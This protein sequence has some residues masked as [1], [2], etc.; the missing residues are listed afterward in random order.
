M[1]PLLPVYTAVRAYRGYRYSRYV[2]IPWLMRKSVEHATGAV[3]SP[4]F[5]FF[6]TRQLMEE[7]R[8]G[9]DRFLDG[10]PAFDAVLVAGRKFTEVSGKR[11]KI[12]RAILPKPDSDSVLH[13][14]LMVK[15]KSLPTLIEDT[16]EAFREQGTKV[17]WYPY[18][19]SHA[20]M[21]GRDHRDDDDREVEDGSLVQ[22]ESVLPFVKPDKRP[23]FTIYRATYS[24]SISI[25]QRVFSEMWK[26]ST[27]K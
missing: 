21:I 4:Q 3:L 17:R 27:A 12:R 14:A 26:A 1:H 7:V 20:I 19:L 24:E 11:T 8:G 23:S 25:F 5:N 2:G 22:V 10:A 16:T 6:Q 18:L 15:D 9:L 13:Y